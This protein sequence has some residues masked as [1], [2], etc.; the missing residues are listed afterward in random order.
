MSG[1]ADPLHKHAGGDTA[2]PITASAAHTML[3]ATTRVQSL[4]ATGQ[5]LNARPALVAQRMLSA[6][7]SRAPAQRMDNGQPEPAADDWGDYQSA[8][9][10]QAPA[11]NANPIAAA[12][13]P[14]PA[15]N[16]V[17]VPAN[18][19]VAAANPVVVA[20]PVGVANQ[21]P[22]AANLPVAANPV[23][24]VA[25]APAP[26]AAP[27]VAAAPLAVGAAAAAV[28]A[29]ANDGL[30]VE[31]GEHS[32][33]DGRMYTTGLVN[34]I[35]LVAYNPQTPLACLYHWNTVVGGLATE[36]DE[37][38]ALDGDGNPKTHFV[39]DQAGVDA[40]KA[41]VDGAVP[42]ATAY[43]AVLGTGWNVGALIPPRA[44]FIAMLGRTFNGITIAAARH[45]SAR[46]VAPDLTGY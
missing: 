6:A 30:K 3:A 13:N 2:N 7:L 19:V 46:W 16:P 14:P 23:V 39:P 45:G 10:Q 29:A 9:A 38:G 11:A 5:M 17:I 27:A 15:A 22:P 37:D 36:E 41:V 26:A 32:A 43:H 31:T 4:T 35:A 42:G 21:P 24:A 12:A 18:P 1:R 44:D 40:A 20:N 25:V 28:P 8:A 34:C 33:L